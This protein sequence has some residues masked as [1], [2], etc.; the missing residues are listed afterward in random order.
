MFHTRK[1]NQIFL[2][3]SQGWGA[4]GGLPGVRPRTVGKTGEQGHT[5]AY[6]M[7]GSEPAAAHFYNVSAPQRAKALCIRAL[8]LKNAAEP[9]M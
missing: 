9:R 4:G 6:R 8:P 1:Q 2:K 5:Q 3:K 7:G